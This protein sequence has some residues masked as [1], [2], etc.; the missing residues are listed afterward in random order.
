VRQSTNLSATRR[1]VALGAGGTAVLLAS[2]D[3]YVVVS[4]LVDIVEDL[5]VPLNRLERATPVVTGFLL[6]YVATMP[7]LAQLSDRW[8]RRPVLQLCIAGFAAGSVLTAAA[9]TLPM[10][11]A[12]RFLQGV[13]G[14][15]LLPVTMAMAA[16]MWPQEQQSRRSAALG[17]VGALQEL[18]SVLGPVYGAALAALV[19]WRGVFWV[20][21]PLAVLAAVAVQL[22]V[23]GGRPPHP[24]QERHMGVPAQERHVGVPQRLRHI[25]GRPRDL[26]RPARATEGRRVDAVGGGLLAVALGLAVVGLYNPAPESSVLPPWGPAAVIASV[27]VFVAFLA[28]EARAR[29]RLFDPAGVQMRVFV[30]ALA[31][32][33]AAGAALLVTL[34]DVQLF[35]QTLL[36][37]DSAGGTELLARFLIALPIGALAGGLL[38]G[39]FTERTV[40]VA[41]MLVSALGYLLISG[42][43]RDVLAAR[44][45]LGPLALPRLDTDLVIAGLGLGLVIAPLSAVVLRA[46][47]AVQHGVA[48]AAVV[49]A[50]MTG[51]MVGVAALAA[52]G[53]RRFRELTATLNT[54]LPFGMPAE[55]YQRQLAVYQ[56]AVQ[57]A[58]LVQYRE[59]FLATAVICLLGALIALATALPRA[60]P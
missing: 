8:G 55:E 38:A 13:A 45:T 33:A 12:G 26:R 59:I 6:G 4:L 19:G 2:L 24:A 57:D 30:A 27:A 28:W 35:A 16:D 41:G 40:T 44:H 54:P 23:H 39:R 9:G 37:R 32:S 43:P 42:W 29:T 52:W 20:N 56:R 47:P 46:V 51:M 5:G 31:T 1:S 17:T 14:G 11:V 34:V 48:S 10:L 15:A 49:M 60:S 21:L 18:G 53:L 50:R 3:T 58:L 7:L 22:T 25:V 36:G